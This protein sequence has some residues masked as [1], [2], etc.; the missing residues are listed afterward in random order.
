MIDRISVRPPVKPL[1]LSIIYQTYV[2][3]TNW[4]YSFGKSPDRAEV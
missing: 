3:V 1:A 4:W 2:W